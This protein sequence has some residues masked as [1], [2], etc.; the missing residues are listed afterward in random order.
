M[1]RENAFP[2]AIFLLETGVMSI[3]LRKPRSLSPAI[4]SAA[5]FIQTVN[6]LINIIIGRI[7]PRT[8]FT[9]KFGSPRSYSSSESALIVNAIGWYLFKA[10]FNAAYKFIDLDSEELYHIVTVHYELYYIVML[11]Y[12]SLRLS[13]RT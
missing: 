2:A 11:N 13:C 1:N 12:N 6:T 10:S 3:V 7:V 5:I 4:D 8:F 9:V